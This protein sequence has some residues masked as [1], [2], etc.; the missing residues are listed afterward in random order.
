MSCSRSP[1]DLLDGFSNLCLCLS[2][3]S[4]LCCAG[5]V[6]GWL[7]MQVTGESVATTPIGVTWL[8]MH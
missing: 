6:P 8:R 2:F 1:S 5:Q 4:S 3:S 7:Q